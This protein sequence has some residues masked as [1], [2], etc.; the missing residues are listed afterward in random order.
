LLVIPGSQ[1]ISQTVDSL[2]SGASHQSVFTVSK[3][4]TT[5]QLEDQFIIAGSDSVWLD[6][7]R[8]RPG[9]DYLLDLRNGIVTLKR[10]RPEFHTMDTTAPHTLVI[11]YE[12]LPFKFRPRYQHREA[13]VKVDTVTKEGRTVSK[14]VRSF[15][16][17]DL[18]RSNLQKNG[19]I[20]RGVTVGS[21]RDLT[22][23][24][25]LRMQMAGNISDNVEVV[26]SLTDENTPI[27]PEGT[28]QT[29]QEI[30]KVFVEIRGTDLSATLGDFQLNLDGNEFG[31]LDRKVQGAKGLANYTTG[32]G[33]GDVI[34]SGATTR[35]KFTTNQYQGL[36]GVQ[37]PYR[38]SGKNGERDI[39]VIAG[40]ERVYVD[41]EQMVR[42]DLNDY[43]IDYANAE[44][45]FA[46][47]R[48]ISAASRITIDFEYT[49]RQF[50][51]NLLAFRSDNRLFK[52]KLKFGATVFREG[53]DQNSPIDVTLSDM[54]KAILHAAG[55][56]R[57]MATK[58]GIDSVGPGKGQYVRLD[59][60]AY[61]PDSMKSVS[62]PIYKF[63][64]WDSLKAIYSVV[65]SYVGQG[66]GDY[67]RAALGR[68]QFAGIRQG[69]YA[70]VRFL[71]MPQSYALADF[72]AGYQVTDDLN[73]A[74]EYALSNRM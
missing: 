39:V 9:K 6:S 59:T 29:L 62:V 61:S 23:N 16:V 65:F 34:L 51:R 37:G 12:A 38:L 25:G 15:S 42:G 58:S 53:D 44:V 72:D 11:R 7:A 67:E 13:V 48:L 17:D 49:D 43:T 71:P 41:G 69:S 21:N 74:G 52:D 22:L 32:L 5:L 40:T 54:D 27:Q 18:F 31:R 3:R 1:G 64:P 30:D 4:D 45:T 10:G 36:D 70:P 20:V 50:T 68:Y 35:G 57:L 24:S 63:A 66:M 26:A 19:S 8:L 46:S 73:V 28:T 60:L 33:T 56:N 55:S 14:P 2:R 47:R